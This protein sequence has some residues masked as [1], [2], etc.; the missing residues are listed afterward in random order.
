MIS[1]AKNHLRISFNVAH[2][3]KNW[4]ETLAS[5]KLLQLLSNS[6]LFKVFCGIFFSIYDFITQWAF[7]LKIECPTFVFDNVNKAQCKCLQLTDYF[8]SKCRYFGTNLDWPRCKKKLF[9]SKNSGCSVIEVL[10]KTN[11]KLIYIPIYCTLLCHHSPH[12]WDRWFF[13]VIFWPCTI[14]L[15]RHLCQ[16]CGFLKFFVRINLYALCKHLRLV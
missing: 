7:G 8:G 4:K 10:Y 1:V 5:R 2:F 13:F 16:K 6:K 9:I 14:Q 12:L 3:I 15:N 11:S